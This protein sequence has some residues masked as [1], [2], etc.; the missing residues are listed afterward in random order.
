WV[1]AGLVALVCGDLLATHRLLHPVA[2]LDLF[3]ARPQVIRLLDGTDS[4]RLYVYDYSVITPLQRQRDPDA[5]SSYRLARVP[6]GWPP[7]AALVLGVYEYLNPPT[8]ARWGLFGSYDLDILGFYPR[9]LARLVELL[10]A[11]EDTPA[12][13][14]L[15]RLGAVANVLALR[16]AKWWNDL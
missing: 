12:H 9:P 2:P 8:A 5:A 15:L 7:G 4:Q 16:P 11:R 3:R 1:A 13:L 6:A 10:R 14:R